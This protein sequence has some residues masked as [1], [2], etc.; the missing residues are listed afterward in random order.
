[1]SGR[2]DNR[3]DLR[4]TFRCTLTPPSTPTL[5]SDYSGG[6]TAEDLV[7]YINDNSGTRAA[8]KKVRV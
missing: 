7:T 4:Y 5:F 8:I 2:Y 1:M 6:R 3:G